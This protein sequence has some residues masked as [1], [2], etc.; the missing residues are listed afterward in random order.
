MLDDVGL[1]DE[2]FFMYYEDTDLAWR[3]RLKGWKIVYAPRA[4]ARHVHCGS[5]IE[6]SR[7]FTFH[8]L[9]NRLAMLLKNAPAGMVVREWM[10]F[11][12]SLL[13][14][15]VKLFAHHVR[16]GGHWVTPLWQDVGVRARV[17]RSLMMSL[18][19]LYWKRRM[20]RGTRRVRDEAI[21]RWICDPDR[22]AGRSEGE[23]IA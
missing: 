6:W 8:V 12:L 13:M 22:T 21:M 10:R 7:F 18:P 5:S 23:K 4:V 3:A 1:L 16:D 19:D 15:G 9:R 2:D 11:L 17:A 20:I 14:R